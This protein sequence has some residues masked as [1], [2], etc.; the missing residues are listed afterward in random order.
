M[1]KVLRSPFLT[2][3][4]AVP[5]CEQA[6]GAKVKANYGVAVNS[7]LHIAC[8]SLGLGSGDPLWTSPITLVASANCGR[9]CGAT[10]EF[11]DIDLATGLMSVLALEQKL[12][13]SEREA[14]LPK[15]VV[16]VHLKYSSCDWRRSDHWQSVMALRCWRMPAMR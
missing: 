12:Q 4:P 6:V 15:V 2:S 13:E 8:L 14:T 3:G 10:V 5:A 16:P 7:A 1:V 9:Y 11:I